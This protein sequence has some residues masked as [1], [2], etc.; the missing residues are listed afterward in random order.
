ME[1]ASGENV[2]KVVEITRKNLEYY[3][4]LF[5]TAAAVFERTDSNFE[6]SSIVGKTQSNGDTCYREITHE[7]KSPSRRPASPLSYFNE[8]PSPC[9]SSAITS[10]VV[11]SQHRS[12]TLH[13][14]KA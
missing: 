5:N 14:P 10:L 9:S 1:S 2:V 6:R 7:R 13:Q 3:I 11:S 12:K 4:N 8:L